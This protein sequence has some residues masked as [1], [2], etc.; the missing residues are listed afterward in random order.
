M[1]LLRQGRVDF[2]RSYYRARDCELRP[3]GPSGGRI[4]I[5]IGGEAPRMLHLAARHAELYNTGFPASPAALVE[6]FAA[7]DAACRDVGRNPAAVGRTVEVRVAPGTGPAAPASPAL[8]TLGG[9]PEEM[10][11]GIAAFHAVGADLVI[12]HLA[13]CPATAAIDV[14]A[15]VVELV[16]AG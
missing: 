2:A 4:P 7:L 9:P 3:R 15:R 11:A 1:P 5:L 12:L 14:L 16:G 13:D 6:R 8:P 10:A